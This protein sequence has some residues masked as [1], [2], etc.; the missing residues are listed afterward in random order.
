MLG[1][2]T[3]EQSSPSGDVGDPAANAEDA[4]WPVS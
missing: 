1:L 2:T 4:E 3:A